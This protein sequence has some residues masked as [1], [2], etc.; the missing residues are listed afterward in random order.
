MKLQSTWYLYKQY[1]QMLYK[2]SIK[3]ASNSYNDY[4][5]NTEHR[6]TKNCFLKDQ[7][8]KTDS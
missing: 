3:M 6:K 2:K 5:K 7:G 4:T 8:E 1:T